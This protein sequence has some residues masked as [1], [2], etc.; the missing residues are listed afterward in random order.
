MTEAAVS[1]RRD[2]TQYI[3]VLDYVS[4]C[5]VLHGMPDTVSQARLLRDRTPLTMKRQENKTIIS[6][7]P[8]AYDPYDTVIEVW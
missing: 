5:I 8:E 7:P 4:D 6:V 3:H 1:T 2:S